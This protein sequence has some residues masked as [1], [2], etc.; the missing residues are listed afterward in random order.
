MN[1]MKKGN[2]TRMDDGMDGNQTRQGDDDWTQ[3]RKAARIT[4]NP[5]TR[6][7]VT[8]EKTARDLLSW[9]F[10]QWSR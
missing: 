7:L 6:K 10:Y 8:E 5:R 4:R 3:V 2:S 1:M 9:H